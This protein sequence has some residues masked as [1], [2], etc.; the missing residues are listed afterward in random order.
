MSLVPPTTVGK[1]QETLHAKAKGSASY[2]FYALYDKVYRADVLEHAYRICQTNGGAPGVDGLRFEDIEKYGRQRWLDE[3]AEELRAKR[4]RPEAVRRV[5]IPKPGQPGRTRPLGIPTIKDRVVMTAAVLVLGPIFEADLQPEQYAYRSERSALDA[6]RQVHALLKSRHWEVIDADLSGYFDSIPHS[7]LLKSVA[8][9]VSDRSLM[10]LIKKWLQAPVEEAAEGG[11]KCRTTRN[12]DEG[13]GCPQGAPISPLLANLYMRRFILGWKTCGHEQ[14]FQAKI[15]NYADDFV[16]CCRGQAE[17]A[18]DAVRSMMGQLKLTINDEKTHLRRLPEESFDFL[19]YTFGRCYSAQGVRY[20]GQRP[21]RKKIQAICRVISEWTELRWCWL[22]VAEQVRRLN[23]LMVG[24]ANY[25]C[26]GPV[27]H[28]Y[29][30]ITNHARERLRR[31]LGRK[32][33]KQG[34]GYTHFPDSYLHGT[35]G[36]TQLRLCD[37]NVPWA[38]A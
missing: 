34:Q 25:F 15:V 27:S 19:G 11:S 35:L 7:E 31:W 16:I 20:L 14:R 24:W 8:R 4:Y 37:R 36:L 18:M 5:L 22:D 17:A 6:V 2:R 23:R 10:G 33:K 28:A 9:R 1:L 3:L 13:R 21:S 32:H 38:T 26:Q 30:K 12:K 29:R